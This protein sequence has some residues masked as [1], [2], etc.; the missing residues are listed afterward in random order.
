VLVG[1]DV[2]DDLDDLDDLDH[3]DHLDHLNRGRRTRGGEVPY[4]RI[5]TDPR[6]VQM[7][8]Y[9]WTPGTGP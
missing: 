8:D 4:P 5:S 2:L 7:D 9:P 6:T 1:E 3:L